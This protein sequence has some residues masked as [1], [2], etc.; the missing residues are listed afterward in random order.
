MAADVAKD[1]K[2]EDATPRRRQEAREQGQVALSTE[3]VAA[4]SIACAFG[5]LLLGGS[6]L[7]GASGE[8]LAHTLAGVGGFGRLELTVPEGAAVLRAAIEPVAMPVALV[9]VPLLAVSLLAAY[10]QVGFRV[11]PKAITLD[12]AK[13]DPIKGLGRVASTKGLVRAL[14]AL[15]KILAISAVVGVVAWGRTPAL[16]RLAG[17][18]V[19]PALA[20]IGGLLSR[21]A[22]AALIAILALAALDWAWQRWQHEGE[23]KMTKKELKE[24]LRSSEGDP[25]LKA[26]IRQ[27]QREMA[28]RRM[29]ADVPTA[30]VVVTNPTH[31]A[32]ALRYER[33]EE[34]C[35]Q[36][37]PTV[38][39]KGVDHAAQRIKEVARG[40]G[41]VLY[42][43]V[44]L[45]RALHAQ[46]EIGEE[47][48]ESLFQA[49]ASVLAYVYRVQGRVAAGAEA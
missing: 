34:G 10:L 27:V 48:P 15:A 2:T 16:S 26:R 25:A 46:V 49:V 47:I 9:V 13:L 4:A 8:L 24:E 22:V 43:D 40:A 11:T 41:V 6:A 33:P 20:A 45:A 39:A 37:A 1:E 35:L 19:G 5:A 44:P 7:A 31:Y 30:T 36:R 18:D 14:L 12:L 3:L 23:L 29:M 42:E 28:R 32:V 38:V 21:C 17:S